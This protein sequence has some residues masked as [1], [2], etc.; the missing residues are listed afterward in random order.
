M[1]PARGGSKALPGKNIAP[2]GGK[3]LIV[4]TID[5]AKASRV[6]SR[7][8]VT[9]DDSEIAEVARHQH[10][11][12]HGRTVPLRGVTSALRLAASTSSR[13]TSFQ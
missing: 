10:I 8:L 5:A 13:K 1:I 9:T 7:T 4:W 12:G 2:L 3:P 11:Y 6:I